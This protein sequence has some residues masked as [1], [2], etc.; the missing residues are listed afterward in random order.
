[1]RIVAFVVWNSVPFTKML[2]KP[3]M[4][5]VAITALIPVDEGEL[6]L[7]EPPPPHA[8]TK[9]AI[10]AAT[11]NPLIFNITSPI[12]INSPSRIGRGHLVPAP[13][14][15]ALHPNC[16]R[17]PSHVGHIAMN[18]IDSKNSPVSV[19]PCRRGANSEAQDFAVMVDPDAPYNYCCGLNGC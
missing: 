12:N 10:A 13:R 5:P 9:A 6:M 16:E 11:R 4:V 17:M 14:A 7:E 2:P 18:G 3:L 8:T 19:R 1:L 15:K